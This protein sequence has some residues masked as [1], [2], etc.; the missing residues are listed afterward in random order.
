VNRNRFT[1][2]LITFLLTTSL[3]L[4][5]APSSIAEKLPECEIANLSISQGEYLSAQT[6]EHGIIVEIR[7]G[8]RNAQTP[9]HCILNGY[10]KIQIVSDKGKILPIA[11]SYG[12]GQYVS[13]RAPKVVT[14]T[15]AH[16]IAYFF[17]AK[18]RCDESTNAKISSIKFFLPTNSHLT[19]KS[20]SLD[21]VGTLDYC[22]KSSI[23]SSNTI[24]V[25]PITSTMGELFNY[26]SSAPTPPACNYST[27]SI[28]KPVEVGVVKAIQL[29]YQRL[30]LTP[31]KIYKNQELVVD[32]I[33]HAEGVHTCTYDGIESGYVG[34][35]PYGATAA[36][37]VA[38][39]HK[40][41]AQTG[42]NFGILYVAKMGTQGWKVVSEGTGP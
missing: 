19:G 1:P 2:I 21:K 31:I 24:E 4:T 11:Y 27:K 12:R 10:P 38:V 28:F 13:K 32:I 29:Y 15:I 40:P 37:Q 8:Y 20:I 5:L 42:N 30:N 16:D 6:G 3:Q 17:L 9:V 35:I 39:T 36:V 23:M 26:P 41:Y 33:L 14:F 34:S 22:G 18:Y 25:S 7:H